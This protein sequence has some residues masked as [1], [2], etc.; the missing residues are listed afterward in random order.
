M[1]VTASYATDEL[2]GDFD[3]KRHMCTGAR[4]VLCTALTP[5][6]RTIGSLIMTRSRKFEIESGFLSS[7]AEFDR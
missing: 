3:G 7:I 4:D 6:L 5:R 2:K 1:P